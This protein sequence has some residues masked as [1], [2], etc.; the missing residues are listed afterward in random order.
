MVFII[1]YDPNTRNINTELYIEPF[2]LTAIYHQQ[3]AYRFR[4]GPKI[5]KNSEMTRYD[6]FEVEYSNFLKYWE[7]ATTSGNYT[8]LRH[9]KD[10]RSFN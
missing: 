5:K 10:D 7:S 3:I 8:T 9:L 6:L 4:S 1:S 2:V